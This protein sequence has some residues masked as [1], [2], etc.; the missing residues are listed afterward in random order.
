M[1]FTG[2][3]LEVAIEAALRFNGKVAVVVD[4]VDL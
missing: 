1:W 2:S 4:S 3:F